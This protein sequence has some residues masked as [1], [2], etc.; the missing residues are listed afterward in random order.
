MDAA[1]ADGR[2]ARAAE[3]E[4]RARGG[5]YTGR[6]GERRRVRQHGT[7][8]VAGAVAGSQGRH[9]YSDRARASQDAA[10]IADGLKT[11]DGLS[12]RQLA[13]RC[14]VAES[15]PETPLAASFAHHAATYTRTSTRPPPWPAPAPTV[16]P[17]ARPLLSAAAP[18]LSLCDRQL[19][20]VSSGGRLHAV[21]QGLDSASLPARSSRRL[22]AACSPCCRGDGACSAL[23]IG[24]ESA[25]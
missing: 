15:R 4:T 1:E 12:R 24:R 20:T 7:S 2:H 25:L 16:V 10:Q 11:G 23:L 3:G 8:R 17:P 5:K 19:L 13:G 18:Q 6:G 21:L 9:K 14:C 22:L